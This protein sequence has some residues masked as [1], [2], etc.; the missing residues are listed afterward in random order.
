MVI[1]K[2][3]WGDKVQVC[4]SWVL[5]KPYKGGLVHFSRPSIQHEMGAFVSWTPLLGLFKGTSRRNR[6][7]DKTH[8]AVGDDVKHWKGK[9]I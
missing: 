1:N 9:A 8:S 2:K 4:K 6:T 7:P 5:R 3:G